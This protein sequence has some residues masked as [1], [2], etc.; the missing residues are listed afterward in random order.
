[1]APPLRV[2]VTRH[3]PLSATPASLS[4]R[5]HMGD[6]ELHVTPA[7]AL[8]LATFY[9]VFEASCAWTASLKRQVDL[10]HADPALL[11]ELRALVRRAAGDA[12]EAAA[13]GRAE[14][15]MCLPSH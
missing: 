2:C 8:R 3:T 1:M 5:V 11:S 13:A 12:A 14:A 6:A 4:V 7:Q 9:D 15:G 10:G